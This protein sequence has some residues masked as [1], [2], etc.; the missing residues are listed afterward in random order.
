MQLA[1]AMTPA[2]C[3][4]LPELQAQAQALCGA[5]TD[6]DDVGAGDRLQ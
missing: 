3:A 4:A 1:P 2:G 6:F 5:L